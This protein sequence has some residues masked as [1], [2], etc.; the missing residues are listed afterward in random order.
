MKK[1]FLKSIFFN[2]DQRL[3][4]PEEEMNNQYLKIF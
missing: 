3:C 2:D 1:Q 4:I